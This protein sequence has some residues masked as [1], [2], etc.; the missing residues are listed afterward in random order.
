MARFTEFIDWP[1]EPDADNPNARFAICVFG[2]DPILA[3][4]A[5][6]PQLLRVKGHPVETR[7]IER[8]D[9]VGKCQILYIPAAAESHLGQIKHEIERRPVLLVN[10]TPGLPF[11]GQ[12]ITLFNDGD[13]LR[14]E[15]H[16]QAA[17][18]AGFKISARL[19]KLAVIVDER[20]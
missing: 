7:R 1:P 3:P 17:Q 19:L 10:E 5:R 2:N 20:E 12:L 15:I 16:L 4:L 9:D 11:R 18:N 13:R 14:L 6:L 8:V